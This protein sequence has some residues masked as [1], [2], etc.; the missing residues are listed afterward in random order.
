VVKDKLLLIAI[1]A[2][3][4]NLIPDRRHP[5]LALFLEL[6]PYAVDVNV[7]PAKA[8]VRFRDQDHVRNFIISSIRNAL[9][10]TLQTTFE[11]PPTNAKP[12]TIS[13]INT[14]LNPFTSDETTQDSKKSLHEKL[15]SIDYF[16]KPATTSFIKSGSSLH[17]QDQFIPQTTVTNPTC[18]T[19]EKLDLEN[20][21]PLGEAKFQI[22]GTYI[23]AHA[24]DG[25]IIVDQHAAH[26]RL[27]LE[28]FKMEFSK[29][30]IKS[31]MLL[32]PEVV[33]LS[34]IAVEKLLEFKPQLIDYGFEFDRNGISQIV[35]RQVPVMLEKSSIS[36]LFKDLAE[37]ITEREDLSS[38][39]QIKDEILGNFACHYSIRSGRQLNIA[40]MENIL[41]EVEVTPLA[42]QCNHGRPTFIKL[43]K[44]KLAKFFE[45]I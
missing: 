10:K 21:H 5:A 43:T 23:V 42:G 24:D 20:D 3:Y 30:K 22:F 34:K 4:Q 28:K 31:Q 35:V 15:D 19:S 44:E 39:D 25:I 29:G 8:E 32:V 26:E 38:L 13:A 33:D 45:R 14:R 37:E 9:R 1:R 40:E 2:A 17:I 11:H 36:N 41:R 6:D 18:T 7:H 16:K 12:Q 27:T